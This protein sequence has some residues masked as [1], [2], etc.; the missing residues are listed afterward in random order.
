M[1]GLYILSKCG[2]CQAIVDGKK[3][4]FMEIAH[5]PKKDRNPFV[6]QDVIDKYAK[7]KVGEVIVI[8]RHEYDAS[9]KLNECHI[10]ARITNIKVKKLQDISDTDCFSEGIYPVFETWEHCFGTTTY[11]AGYTFGAGDIVYENVD[12]AF[13]VLLNVIFGL[14]TWKANPYVWIYDFELLKRHSDAEDYVQ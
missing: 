12:E 3:T 9:R 5:I 2:Q 14:G 10:H 13:T 1:Q 7:Y 6:M 4:Q 8:S 11:V